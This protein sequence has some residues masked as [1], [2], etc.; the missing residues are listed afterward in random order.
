[1]NQCSDTNRTDRKVMVVAAKFWEMLVKESFDI[2]QVG[3]DRRGE[4][5]ICIQIDILFFHF[6][7]YFKSEV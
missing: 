7:S 2:P 5:N 1:M 6:D 3:I 4:C